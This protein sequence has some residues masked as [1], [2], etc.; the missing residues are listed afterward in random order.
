MKKITLFCIFAIMTTISGLSQTYSTG[1]VSLSSSANFTV[2]F[3]I[4][5]TNDE[6]TMTM[7]GDSDVWLGVAPGVATGSG[8]G[9]SGD[10]VIVFSDSGLEDRNMTG[11]TVQPNLDGQEDWT[12]I[13]NDVSSNLRTIVATRDLSTGDPNDYVF[14]EDETSFPLLF[15]Y[16]NNTL[17]LS[18]HGSGRGGTVA[19]TTLSNDRFEAIEISFD[20]YPNPTSEELNI[21]FSNNQIVENSNLEVY[22]VL[23]KRVYTQPIS[24]LKTKINVGHW[25]TGIYLIKINNSNST[26]TKRFIKN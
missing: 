10:D 11:N 16:G 12:V 4:D 3:D 24:N 23:G 7:V 26:Q 13:S 2:Q 14:P 15:A 22:N 20:L 19:N 17:N 25:D 18:Y 6:V 9:N 21:S 1:T 5:T 8:M